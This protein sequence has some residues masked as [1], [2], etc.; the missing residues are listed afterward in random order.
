VPDHT[1]PVDDFLTARLERCTSCGATLG[2]HHTVVLTV[3]DPPVCVAV[4]QCLPCR[5]RDPDMT[6]LA[7]LLRQRYLSVA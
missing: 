3:R 6:K 1:V 5:K 2:Q 4:A 7:E